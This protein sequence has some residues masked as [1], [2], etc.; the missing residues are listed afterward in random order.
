MVD[1]PRC[2]GCDGGGSGAGVEGTDGGI[3]VGTEWDRRCLCAGCSFEALDDDLCLLGLSSGSISD[4][5]SVGGVDLALDE[6]RDAG[7]LWS[8]CDLA[9][10]RDVGG[11]ADGID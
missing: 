5:T 4:P 6:A 7:V 11:C 3:I 8:D 10:G 2:G 1:L 9:L